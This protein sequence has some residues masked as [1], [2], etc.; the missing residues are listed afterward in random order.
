MKET[1]NNEKSLDAKTV[2]AEAARASM[3][4]TA[5]MGTGKIGKLLLE[6]CIP[7][8][9]GLLVNAIYNVVDRIYIGHGVGEAA[10]AGIGLVMPVMM[11]IAALSIIVGVGANSLFSIRMGQGRADEV[12]KIMG[13]A[14]TL[15]FLI[16]AVGIVLCMVFLEPLIRN[17]LKATDVLYPYTKSYLEIIL[18]GS[19]FAAMSPGLTNFI[20]SDGHPK[21]S[22]LVQI[23][24]AV[25]NIIL[26]PIFIF[27]FHMGVAGAAWA[28][29]ISQFIS[30]V[31]VL[32]YFNSKWT[33]LRFRFRNMPLDFKL[34]AEILAIGFAPFIMQLAMSLVG[35]VQNQQILKYGSNEAL[36]AMTISVSVLIV[37]MMPMHGI[38]QGAQPIIG[39][40][41]GAR[42]YDRVKRTFLTALGG[43]TAMLTL[44][45]IMSHVFPG[46][47]FSVF[48]PDKG[49]LRKLGEYVI[50][51][52][53]LMFP[54][55]GMQI[56]GG[57]FFQ[58][59][60]KPVQGT[61]ISLSRQLLFFIPCLY[62]LPLLWE[63]LG[64]RG[65]MGVYWAFPISDIL[66]CIVSFFFVLHE[67]RAM[68][69]PGYKPAV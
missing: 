26:D 36:E 17:V 46:L 15:L 40:N 35:I 47:L 10:L 54:V 34:S 39:Y 67:F 63:A 52:T 12:E 24:G 21:T 62:L 61:V 49:D 7:A 45:F 4:N 3:A 50:R 29:I 41:Y 48:S 44:G 68:S 33:K 18:Y 38:G 13:N 20:R 25:A 9:V 30:L 58:S 14:F 8:M 23:V 42:K 66:A 69:K 22:M 19:I 56:M 11:V 16:P 59:I 57:Q 37:I 51:V 53:T 32:S 1:I 60:G 2:A 55:I 5:R 64:G 31:F 65:I 27:G 43:C 28:T 6:F